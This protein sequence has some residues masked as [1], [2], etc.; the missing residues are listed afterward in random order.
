M[1]SRVRRAHVPTARARYSGARRGKTGVA[2]RP[3]GRFPTP[4]RPTT[5]SPETGWGRGHPAP[6]HL[7]NR[8]A[9]PVGRS[10][11]CS[12]SST[13]HPRSEVST[14]VARPLSGPPGRPGT[15]LSERPR[16]AGEE[17]LFRVP[18]VDP[19]LN[20]KRGGEVEDLADV[21]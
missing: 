16:R 1:L 17:G 7:P 8:A 10:N 4:A 2:E 5:G 9:I 11:T 19:E 18:D 15:P 14:P 20:G 12:N 13:L 3:D 21:E 6:D